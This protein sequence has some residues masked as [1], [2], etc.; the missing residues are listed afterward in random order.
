MTKILRGFEEL[1]LLLCVT[2]GLETEE[3]VHIGLSR[4]SLTLCEQSEG[5]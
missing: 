4:P 1:V 5:D 2:A 3:D